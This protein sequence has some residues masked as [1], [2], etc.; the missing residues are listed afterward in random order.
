MIQQFR[1]CVTLIEKTGVSSQ[2]PH[3]DLQ[4]TVIPVTGDLT[5]PSGILQAPGTDMYTGKT[6]RVK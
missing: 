4:S 5:P 3:W 6:V 1:V 2:H